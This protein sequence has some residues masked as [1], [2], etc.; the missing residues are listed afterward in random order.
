MDEIRAFFDKYVQ[1]PRS[2][3]LDENHHYVIFIALFILVIFGL[4]IC[5]C[6]ICYWIRRRKRRE[7]IDYPSN[8][9]QY[10]RF[11]RNQPR[12]PYRTPESTCS[13]SKPILASVPEN[14]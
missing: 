9:L 12:K 4:L 13:S 3:S 11:P 6:C 10:M 5:N 7:L 14:V 1:I 8:T 2:F